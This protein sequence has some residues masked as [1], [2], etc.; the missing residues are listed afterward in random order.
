MNQADGLHPNRE[1]VDIIVRRIAP[2]VS[3]LLDGG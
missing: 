2:Y 1:G 3:R